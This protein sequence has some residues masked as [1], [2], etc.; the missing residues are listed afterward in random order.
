MTTERTPSSNHLC[1][2]RPLCNVCAWAV[3]SQNNDIPQDMSQAPT[4]TLLVGAGVSSQGTGRCQ[5]HSIVLFDRSPW[6]YQSPHQLADVIEGYGGAFHRPFQVTGDL[7]DSPSI[8]QT[9]GR[10]PL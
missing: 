9:E 5:S 10:K 1:L 6:T 3:Q 4:E 2:Y 8:G 7:D